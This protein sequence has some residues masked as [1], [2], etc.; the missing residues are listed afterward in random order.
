MPNES[1]LVYCEREPL[2]MAIDPLIP[3]AHDDNE[4]AFAAPTCGCDALVLLFSQRTHASATPLYP[5][6]QTA[7]KNRIKMKDVSLSCLPPI[8]GGGGTFQR[9]IGTGGSNYLYRRSAAL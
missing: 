4:R 3:S 8:S 9:K 6:F 5:L 1:P 7:A 2:I